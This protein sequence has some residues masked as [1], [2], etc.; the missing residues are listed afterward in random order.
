ME[1]VEELDFVDE[2]ELVAVDAVDELVDVVVDV[3]DDVVEAV[4]HST[5]VEADS[6]AASARIGSTFPTRPA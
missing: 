3:Y 2:D 4:V 5:W 6:A 1:L